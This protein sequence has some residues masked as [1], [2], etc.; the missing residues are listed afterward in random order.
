MNNN[1]QKYTTYKPSGVEWLGE[2]PEHWKALH[3]KYIFRLKKNLV[4]KKSH[5]YE[6]LSLT[7]FGVIKRDMENPQGKFPAEFDTYQEVK[8]GDFIFCL[9]DV[10]ETPRTVGLSEF[11]GM[12]T[13]AYTVFDVNKS[14]DRKFLYYFYL[15]LDNGKRMKPLYT[16]LRNTI[17]KDNFF[18]FRTL[19]PPL[20]EQ[21]R[22]AEFLDRKT[23][24][25]DQAVTIKEKQI[26]LLK[27]R[28]QILIHRAVTRGINPDVKLKPS[29][30]EWIGDIPEHWEVIKTKFASEFIYDGTHGSYPRVETGFRLLSVRNI[31]E[32]NFVFRDDDSRISEKHFKEISNKFLVSNGDIQLAIVGATLGKVAIV[33]NLIE[34]IVTQRSVCTIRANNVCL[35][36]FIFYFIKSEPFQNYLWLNAGFSAQPGVYLG[37]IQ[38]SY[39]T[40]PPLMEQE[41]IVNYIKDISKKI[42]TA[43]KLKEQEIEKLKEYKSTLI[44]SAVTGK[45]RV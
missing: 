34:P 9:F 2:I 4:G 6:L 33:E 38:N 36:K 42:A 23:A 12:I 14:F 7:L 41:Q 18:A 27:E 29:G 31:I 5:L 11:D 40:R 16:G 1:I 32:D 30:V 3:N 28:R 22:I 17:S 13:G 25:I 37:T 43:I 15:N 20:S 24:Q 26:A 10:E 39:L 45:V 21:T 8:K 19:I 35:T 44:N